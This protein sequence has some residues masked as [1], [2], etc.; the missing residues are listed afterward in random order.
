MPDK[1]CCR[2]TSPDGHHCQ[3]TDMGSGFCFWHDAKFDK[4]GLDLTQIRALCKKGRIITGIA[5]KTR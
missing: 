1:P 3:E 2:Y 4:S 5:I